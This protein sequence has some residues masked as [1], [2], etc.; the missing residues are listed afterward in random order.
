VSDPVAPPR[1]IFLLVDTDGW[2]I[3]PPFPEHRAAL[4]RLEDAKQERPSSTPIRVVEYV[5]AE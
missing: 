3:G 5:R 1:R 4:A 2:T